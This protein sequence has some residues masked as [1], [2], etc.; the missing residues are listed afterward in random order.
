[1]NRNALPL[2]KLTKFSPLYPAFIELSESDGP[3]TIEPIEPIEPIELCDS[4]GPST[5]EPHEPNELSDSDGSSDHPHVFVR[6]S[7]TPDPETRGQPPR[8]R[9]ARAQGGPPPGGLARGRGLG[10]AGVAAAAGCPERGAQIE[11][12]AQD[13]GTDEPRDG[14]QPPTMGYLLWALR[15]DVSTGAQDP[16]SVFLARHVNKLGS[17]SE[18]LLRSHYSSYGRVSRVMAPPIKTKGNCRR[19]SSP[20]IRLRPATIAL[21]VMEHHQSVECILQAGKKQTVA[22]E[23]ICVEPFECS[24]GPEGGGASTDS[25]PASDREQPTRS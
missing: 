2:T 12:G 24:A 5:I 11:R 16:R 20:Q 3:S 13:I 22:G 7:S 23:C 18:K 17:E 19:T 14:Q 9:G 1:M 25:D 4:D 10:G 15:R 8:P 21:V 6:S